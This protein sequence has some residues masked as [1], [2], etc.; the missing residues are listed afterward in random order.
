M[1]LATSAAGPGHV[2]KRHIDGGRVTS[3][4]DRKEAP[5]SPPRDLAG[6]QGCG[7]ADRRLPFRIGLKILIALNTC[8]SSACTQVEGGLPGPKEDDPMISALRGAIPHIGVVHI[9]YLLIPC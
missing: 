9:L 5:S 6:L 2:K 8:D 1:S 4:L 7:F 3:Y